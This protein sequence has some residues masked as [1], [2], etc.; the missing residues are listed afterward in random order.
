MSTLQR[1]WWSVARGARTFRKGCQQSVPMERAIFANSV[2]SSTIDR[3]PAQAA[4]VVSR[5]QQLSLTQI[6]TNGVFCSHR[7]PCQN[8]IAYTPVLNRLL[9]TKTRSFSTADETTSGKGGNRYSVK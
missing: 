8:S 4:G 9:S 6:R 1:T 5:S 3:I 7:D 2:D